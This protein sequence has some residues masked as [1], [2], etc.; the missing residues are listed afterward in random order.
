MNRTAQ[1][2]ESCQ[3]LSDAPRRLCAKRNVFTTSPDKQLAR[4]SSKLA[5]TDV[6]LESI[7]TRPWTA[8]AEVPLRKPTPLI[9]QPGGEALIWLWN[10]GSEQLVKPAGSTCP[11]G[12]NMGSLQN[13]EKPSRAA[14]I[15]SALGRLWAVLRA[16]TNPNINPKETKTSMYGNTA[17][18]TMCH[19]GLSG[20]TAPP[21]AALDE[22]QIINKNT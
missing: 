19:L 18:T 21:S 11:Q 4:S 7:G 10:V 6:Q 2:E 16:P 8:W 20:N 12:E 17:R 14:L 15:C 1:R 13:R 22:H 9:Q 5:L 3:L